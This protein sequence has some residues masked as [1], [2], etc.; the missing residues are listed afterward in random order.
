MAMST[1]L[2]DWASAVTV[3]GA[4][5]KIVLTRFQND[6]ASVSRPSSSEVL[7]EMIR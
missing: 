4:V 5:G 2:D 1:A 3:T 6:D 7:R